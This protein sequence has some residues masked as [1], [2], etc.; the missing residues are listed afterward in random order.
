VNN[1]LSDNMSIGSRSGGGIGLLGAGAVLIQRN[2]IAR[3][4]TVGRYGCGWD[5]GIAST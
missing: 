4:M 2:I 5:G 1:E 3:N